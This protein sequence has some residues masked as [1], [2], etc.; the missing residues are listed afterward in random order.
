MSNTSLDS[1]LL[2][3]SSEEKPEADGLRAFDLFGD[4]ELS[5]L[6]IIDRRV[7]SLGELTHLENDQLISLSRPAG[8]NIDL[9]V[10][11]VLIGSAEILVTDEKLAVRV[12]ELRDKPASVPA[13]NPALVGE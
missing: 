2:P 11:D 8:E 5:V 9:L 4:V 3:S 6:A 7:I 1:R 13:E 10:G 12:A